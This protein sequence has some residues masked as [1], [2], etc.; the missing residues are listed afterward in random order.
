MA[1]DEPAAGG[2]AETVPEV[3][4]D[5]ARRLAPILARLEQMKLDRKVR[6]GEYTFRFFATRVGAPTDG[7]ADDDL[8][9]TV[10]LMTAA[11]QRVYRA[12]RALRAADGNGARIRAPQILAA[13]VAAESLDAPCENS[14]RRA[15]KHLEETGDVYEHSEQIG[16]LLRG[17]QPGLP[18]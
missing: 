5:C 4:A 7:S 11:T 16:Y 15:L 12:L 13:M 17:E 8:P 10:Q 2:R 14:V 9:E 3:L 1:D 6:E 18:F